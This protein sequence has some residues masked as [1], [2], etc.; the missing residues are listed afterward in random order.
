MGRIVRTSSQ[1]PSHPDL[2]PNRELAK[3]ARGTF[4]CGTVV[5]A[6]ILQ[7]SLSQGERVPE[8][9]EGG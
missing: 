5:I 2:L 3:G 8:R 1:I 6:A 4:T 9:S 7:A